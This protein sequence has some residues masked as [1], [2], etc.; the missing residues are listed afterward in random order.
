MAIPGAPW[1]YWIPEGIR[2]LFRELPKLGNVAQPRQGLA[3]AD[4]FRFLRFWWEVGLERIAFDCRDRAVARATEKRWFPYMKGGAYRK[5]YGNQEYVV[6]WKDDGNEIKAEIVRRYPYLNG[7]WEWVA[8]NTAYYFREGVTWSKVTSGGFSIR[9]TPTGFIFDVA[10]TSVFSPHEK[11]FHVAGILNSHSIA[12]I[13]RFIFPTV[14]YEVGHIASLPV[15]NAFAN[16]IVKNA[17]S[18]GHPIPR[19]GFFRRLRA[20]SRVMREFKRNGLRTS[21]WK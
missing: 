9:Y 19:I 20:D 4:N 13:L 6:N 12:T 14:N 3:T 15:L 1:V 10:G 5:W 11:I 2:R 8:K 16:G 17:A 7:N 18:T 21:A